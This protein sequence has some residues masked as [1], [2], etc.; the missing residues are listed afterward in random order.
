MKSDIFSIAV[1][2][3]KRIGVAMGYKVVAS[4]PGFDVRTHSFDLG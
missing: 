4:N 3:M 2:V 1:G